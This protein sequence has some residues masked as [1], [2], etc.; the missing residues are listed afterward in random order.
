MNIPFAFT[1]SETLQNDLRQN[2]GV[3]PLLESK[4]Y[5]TRPCEHLWEHSRW[6]A[7]TVLALGIAGLPKSAD[8]D[9]RQTLATIAALKRIGATVET[10]T[11]PD[12]LGAGCAHL[13]SLSRLQ[14]LTLAQTVGTDAGLLHMRK[15]TQLK[16]LHLENTNVTAAGVRELKKALPKL[17]I[18]R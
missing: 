6:T 13:A 10:D 14:Y 2:F 11:T 8:A 16:E 3:K 4:T 1:K 17:K 15:L 5:R 9:D 12:G 18:V 7:L